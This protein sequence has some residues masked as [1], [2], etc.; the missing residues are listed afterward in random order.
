MS[1]PNS[2]NCPFPPATINSKQEVFFFNLYFYWRIIALQNF[3]LFCQTSTWIRHIGIHISPPFWTSLPSPSPSHPSR[4]IQ[5]PCFLSHTVNSHWLSILH[6][7]MSV[8]MLLFLYISPFPPLSSCPWV[9]SPHLFLHCCPVK[10]FSTIFLDSLYMCVKI[11]YISFSFWLTSLCIIASR[12]IHLI[13]TDSNVF[14][15]WLSNS[16]LCIWSTTSLS[17]HLPMDI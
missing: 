13:R 14:F 16:P 7:V 3:V 11:W 1:I 8:S 5:S 15:L 2:I 17:I 9:Y 4:L 10:F 12:F 6:I